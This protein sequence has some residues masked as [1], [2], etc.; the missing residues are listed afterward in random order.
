VSELRRPRPLDA[1]SVIFA[2]FIFLVLLSQLSAHVLGLAVLAYEPSGS[3]ILTDAKNI[4]TVLAVSAA[5]LGLAFGSAVLLITEKKLAVEIDVYR[6]NGLPLDSAVRLML[7][8][9]PIRPLTWLLGAALVAVVA[10]L[11]VG[12]NAFIPVDL[13]GCFTTLLVGWIVLLTARNFSRRDFKD[14]RGGRVG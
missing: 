13:V 9:H 3:S 11:A 14:T 8:F 7:S 4:S 12:L 10:D 6:A 1:L 5:V 2:G